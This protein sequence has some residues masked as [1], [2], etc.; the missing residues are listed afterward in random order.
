LELL[1]ER[2]EKA[3]ATGTVAA[4]IKS[5]YG[6]TLESERKMLRVVR[7]ARELQPMPLWATFLALHALPKGADLDTYVE[8]AVA[9]WLPVLADE[10]LVD[11]V[12]VFC[13]ANYFRPIDVHQLAEAAAKRGIPLKAHVNQFQ[14]IG[15]IQASVAANAR[16]VDHLEVLTEADLKSLAQAWAHGNGPMPVALPHC[17]LFLDIPFT[18]G[19][20]LIDAGLPLAIASDCNPGSAPSS[21]LRMAWSLATHQMK[22]RVDEGLAALTANAAYAVGAEDRMGRI[23]PGMDAHVILTQPMADYA[24]LPYFTSENRIAQTLIYGR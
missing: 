16:S 18:P 10:G 17:S 21:D 11:F 3:R 20:A 15:G 14:S 24:E 5:G 8:D 13:E 12:D 1:L 7:R 2:L 22:L 23:Q 6:L 9:H 19:R 4:E